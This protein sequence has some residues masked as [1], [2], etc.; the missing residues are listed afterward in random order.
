MTDRRRPSSLSSSCRVAS[1]ADVTLRLKFK[2][3]SKDVSTAYLA[4]MPWDG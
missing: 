1:A 2:Q 3:H 4:R